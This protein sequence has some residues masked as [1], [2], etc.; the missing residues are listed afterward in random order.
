MNFRLARNALGEPLLRS[1]GPVRFV[2]R[3]S[4]RGAFCRFRAGRDRVVVMLMQINALQMLEFRPRS[5]IRLRNNSG[6]ARLP[7]ISREQ[8]PMPEH[9]S[10]RRNLLVGA[11]AAASFA[12]AGGA[13]AQTRSDTAP[14][15]LNGKPVPE[16]SAEQTAGPI[17]PGRGTALN[18]KVAVVTGAARG[19]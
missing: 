10:L 7:R 4:D 9:N 14:R 1:D 11:A 12:A 19:I 18:G 2:G 17:R 3:R 15:E 5:A 16:P 6:C 13:S 8:E